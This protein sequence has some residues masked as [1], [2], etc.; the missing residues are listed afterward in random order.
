[1]IQRG[2]PMFLAWHIVWFA[3][4]TLSLVLFLVVI[5]RQL[6]K[7]VPLF[8]IHS[9]WT[10]LAGMAVL[11]MNYAP[12]VSGNR[13]FTGTAVSNG[14]EAVLAFA[15]IYQIFSQR[16]HHYPSV[17]D[18]GS[19]AFRVSTLV[20]LA[21]VLALAWLAPGPGPRYWTSFSSVIQRSARTLQCGQLVFLFLFCN[22]FRL[23]WRS[24]TFGIA[25]G[26][27]IL[28]SS[29]LAINAIQSQLM[30]AGLRRI[31]YIT[32]LANESAYLIAVLV[33][34]SY[35]LAPEQTPEP[36]DGPLPPHDLETWNRELERLLA[37]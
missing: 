26:L 5:R 31:E 21:A 3:R 20:L 16:L 2:S 29:S 18:L 22:Y 23:S 6:Y 28:T 36:P 19:A 12:F 24:R 8:A 33:W 11:A 9:G 7:Q 27:G 14:V 34:L 30:S 37:P 25:L 32:G 17:R 4:V 1:M 15:I 13:Y 35:I 10:A